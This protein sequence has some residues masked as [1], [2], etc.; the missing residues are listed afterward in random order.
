MIAINTFLV[1]S[2]DRHQP[3]II[4]ALTP[5]V[6]NYPGLGRVVSLA[7][8]KES[9]SRGL[10]LK[11]QN[12]I[13]QILKYYEDL[14]AL[15]GLT[16]KKLAAQKSKLNIFEKTL[17]RANFLAPQ[18]FNSQEIENLSVVIAQL[19]ESNLQLAGCGNFGT[20][21]L[22]Q[23]EDANKI[24]NLQDV[25]KLEPPSSAFFGN[26]ISGSVSPDNFFVL[27]VGDVFD[28]LSI[29]RLQK[30][31][32]Q[33]GSEHACLFLEK[34]LSQIANQPFGGIIAS[35]PSKLLSLKS[36]SYQEFRLLSDAAIKKLIRAKEDKKIQTKLKQVLKQLQEI[37]QTYAEFLAIIKDFAQ[38][39][40]IKLKNSSLSLFR[41]VKKRAV[42]IGVPLLFSFLIG[43]NFLHANR[44][45][46]LEKI[47]L[48]RNEK[49]MQKIRADLD[50]AESNLI[51]KNEDQA[52]KVL[53]SAQQLLTNLRA[54]NPIPLKEFNMKI[55][56]LE[57]KINHR[58]LVNPKPLE[59]LPSDLNFPTNKLEALYNQTAYTVNEAL[60]Q[61]NK[62]QKPWLNEGLPKDARPVSLAI[63]GYVYLALADGQ[64]LKFNRGVKQI[65]SIKG[66][67]PPLS[68]P[69]HIFTTSK[70][71][72]LYILEKTRLVVVSKK[73]QQ[74][75]TQYIS[76]LFDNL[77]N[78][79]VKDKN[80]Y[81]KNGSKFLLMEL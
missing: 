65:F 75:I 27:S 20:H 13:S 72:E 11:A 19:G 69:I 50:E 59:N 80:I 74:V 56:Q 24:L 21:F 79:I 8:A 31:L 12:F 68:S 23:E 38:S 67:S 7:Y 5:L 71:N 45:Q 1:Q 49:I 54:D 17:E 47:T 73:D 78:L 32:T 33:S 10:M 41:M 46:N 64:I 37:Y 30:L 66:L 16:P 35:W 62:N 28:Y 2:K 58:Q 70:L 60:S 39:W 18:T 40:I 25:N 36:L 57:D 77:E 29:N 76:P 3:R 43:A 6:K 22:Y 9:S 51:Y 48:E 42:F 61:I 81:V 52:K 14:P 4:I 15:L 55:R 34:N 53:A 26:L 44:A 63:D